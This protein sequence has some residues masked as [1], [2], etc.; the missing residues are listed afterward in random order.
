MILMW[1]GLGGE[2]PSN[3]YYDLYRCWLALLANGVLYRLIAVW[4]LVRLANPNTKRKGYHEDQE[5]IIT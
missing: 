5:K 2:N 4:M 3:H 1:M